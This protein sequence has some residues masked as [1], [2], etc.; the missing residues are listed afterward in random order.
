[1]DFS[2]KS[3]PQGQLGHAFMG[4]FF[5]KPKSGDSLGYLELFPCA[6]IENKPVFFLTKL[7]LCQRHRSKVVWL[8][9]L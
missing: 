6:S 9:F 7:R 8:H 5:L 4:E 2:A 3:D 1:M